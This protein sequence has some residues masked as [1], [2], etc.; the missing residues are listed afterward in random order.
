MEKKE[1]WENIYQTKNI[2]GVSWYQ[3]TPHESIELIKKFST[4]DSD[5]IIDIGCGKS[6]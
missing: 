4:T 3:E 5:M 1:H 6:F 2:D